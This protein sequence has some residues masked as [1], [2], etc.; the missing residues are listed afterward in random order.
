[1]G[2]I[3]MYGINE[4]KANILLRLTKYVEAYDWDKHLH[5]PLPPLVQMFGWC[6]NNLIKEFNQDDNIVLVLFP[7]NTH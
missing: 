6:I 4:L 3:N 1:M 5:F 7:L 2:L